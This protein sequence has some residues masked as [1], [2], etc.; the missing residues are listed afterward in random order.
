M[1]DIVNRAMRDGGVLAPGERVAPYEALRAMTITGAW[2]HNDEGR[3]GSLQPGKLADLVILDKNPLMVPPQAIGD[4]AVQETIKE[5][6]TVWARP[7][8][9]PAPKPAAAAHAGG[10]DEHA[11]ASPYTPPISQAQKAVIGRLFSQTGGGA[12]SAKKP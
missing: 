6:R 9:G 10:D 12:G 4:I 11:T 5:G 8:G 7:A 1:Q 2:A 3:K